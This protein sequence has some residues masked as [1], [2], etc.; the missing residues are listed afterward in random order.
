[1]IELRWMK[2]KDARPEVEPVLQWRHHILA[3]DAGM[4]LSPTGQWSPWQTTPLVFTDT[5]QSETGDTIS[6]RYGE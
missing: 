3:V 4:N 6:Q 1:M 2:L 5:S